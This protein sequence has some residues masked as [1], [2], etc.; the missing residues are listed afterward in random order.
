MNDY[1]II[2][3]RCILVALYFMEFTRFHR[4]KKIDPTLQFKMN[5][6]S[7]VELI[8]VLFLCAVYFVYPYQQNDDA[9]MS[10]GGLV[11]VMIVHVQMRRLVFAGKSVLFVTEQ[12]FWISKIQH[13]QCTDSKRFVVELGGKLLRVY[14]PVG[15]MDY[16]GQ[17]LSSIK[18]KRKKEE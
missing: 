15:D 11:L 6:R 16:V 18:A 4:A 1:L 3:M 8:A 14:W 13:Y 2:L 12:A 5:G 10:V 9:L 17:R 7:W